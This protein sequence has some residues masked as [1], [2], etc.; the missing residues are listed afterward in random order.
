MT[1]IKE[2]LYSFV[3]E[4]KW[5][6]YLII[7][8]AALVVL[9]SLN[10]KKEEG[11]KSEKT[12][13]KTDIVGPKSIP[14]PI[15]FSMQEAVQDGEQYFKKTYGT[16]L[17]KEAQYKRYPCE[18]EACESVTYRN[19][20][21]A[22]FRNGQVFWFTLEAI[23]LPFNTESIKA[24]GL[25][26]TKPDFENENVITWNNYNGW[27]IDF[28]ENGKGKISFILAKRAIQ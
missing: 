8:C 23:D 17:E 21:T 26:P 24:L 22:L 2:L 20:N 1:E 19:K 3:P 28:N 25:Q 16:P 12:E 11:A 4:A 9:G 15:I 13:E 27:H 10:P 5:K 14:V 18:K 7:T 6:Q